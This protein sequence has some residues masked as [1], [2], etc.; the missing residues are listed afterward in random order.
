MGYYSRNSDFRCNRLQKW[1]QYLSHQEMVSISPPL[2]TGLTFFDQKNAREATLCE[3]QTLLPCE[4]ALASLLQDER[5]HREGPRCYSL[6]ASHLSDVQVRPFRTSRTQAD[7]PNDCISS[8]WLQMHE[9]GRR[10]TN[11]PLSPVQIADPQSCE[12]NNWMLF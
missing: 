10:R 5:S 11:C 1:S 7:Q 6:I 2:E 9:L 8:S 12:L 4:Q 3:F